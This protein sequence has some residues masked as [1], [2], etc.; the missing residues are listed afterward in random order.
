[1]DDL[2]R[3]GGGAVGW[4]I[5]AIGWAM[6]WP[7]S[8]VFN[9]AVEILRLTQCVVLQGGVGT[10][11][12][13]AA[14][15]GGCRLFSCR[16]GIAEIA[17]STTTGVGWDVMVIGRASDMF[18]PLVL[19]AAEILNGS[20]PI[21]P[22]LTNCISG[23]PAVEAVWIGVVVAVALFVSWCALDRSWLAQVIWEPEM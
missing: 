3:S 21:Q 19:N 5:V 20:L 10:F 18:V 23:T 11:S 2:L 22:L 13:W 9:T 15:G 4:E 12:V 6:D 17:E 1:M 14:T 7:G 8:L 16:G